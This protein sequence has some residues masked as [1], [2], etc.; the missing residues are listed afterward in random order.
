VV[1]IV[2]ADAD[3]V[4][5]DLLAGLLAC[6]SCGG[7]LRPWGHAEPRPLR[8]GRKEERVHPRRSICRSCGGVRGRTHVLLPDTTLIRRRDHVEV[9]VAAIEA[10]AAGES[11]AAVASRLGVDEGTVRG[12]LRAF[13]RN[14]EVIRSGFTRW[15]RALEPSGGPIEPEQTAFKDALAA[16]GVAVRAAVL[17]FGPRPASSVVSRLSCGA[18]LCHTDVL[19]RCLAMI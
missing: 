6:P 13:A 11:R 2:D 10:R 19:Y 1:S 3:K 7:A 9:I 15:A 4:E 18:L 5:A 16:I 12:W 8:R 17:R 14:V